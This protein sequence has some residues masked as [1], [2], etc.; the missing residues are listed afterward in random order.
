MDIQNIHDMYGKGKHR[1]NMCR[2]D[3]H[4][5]T[6]DVHFGHV[7]SVA[8]SPILNLV[9]FLCCYFEADVLVILIH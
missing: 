1:M 6:M 8:E 4:F 7:G 9:F 3:V 5:G 2:C